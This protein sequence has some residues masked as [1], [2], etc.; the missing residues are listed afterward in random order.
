MNRSNKIVDLLNP[1]LALLL[2]LVLLVSCGPTG[3]GAETTAPAAPTAPL[4]AV[5]LQPGTKLQA[6]ATTTIIGD[7]VRQV[8]GDRV[9]VTTLL[10]PGADPHS[11][12]ARPDDMRKLSAAQV[13]FVNGLHL[14]EAMQ[15][16]LDSVR[17]AVPVVAVNAGVPT[18]EF[19]AH[20]DE[21]GAAPVEARVALDEHDHGGAD[22]HT[23]M[24]VGNVIRWAD[25][26]AAALGE[27]DPA[28]AVVYE[29]NATAY[30]QEL[31][32]LD[33]EIRAALATIPL[34]RRKLVTDHDNLSYL[35][36]AYGLEVIGAVIPAISTMAAASAQERATLQRQIQEQG[37]RA[38]LVDA[39]VNA[40][41]AR[42]LA[43][44][45]GVPVVTV[46]TG[47]LSAADGPAPTYV[48]MMRHTISEIVQ[49][50]R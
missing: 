50:L 16:T 24:D 33:K 7:V 47:S 43:A 9:A 4:Q 19:G 15:P 48:E 46:Y 45:T 34:E 25:T 3:G 30:K 22:P 26:I 31:T 11:Y 8:G 27:L 1:A 28:G 14:E 44:D 29:R 39:T 13:V 35:A 23:W 6:V 2:G 21:H 20:E 32:A 37:V 18:I 49:A 40:D 12:Q 38:I 10:P 42:Q 5:N 36:Q 17:G 41:V